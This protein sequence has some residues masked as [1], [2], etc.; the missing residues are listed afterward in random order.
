[1]LPREDDD[2]AEQVEEDGQMVP[3]AHTP[4]TRSPTMLAPD[5]SP[6]QFRTP[7]THERGEPFGYSGHQSDSQVSS[8]SNPTLASLRN[9]FKEQKTRSLREL[10]DQN[11]EVDHISNFSLM[12]C[13]PVSFDEATKEDA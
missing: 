5:F 2:G 3:H 6:S 13:D 9:I 7:R 10:Y 8:E 12:A 11:E 1:V 4:A